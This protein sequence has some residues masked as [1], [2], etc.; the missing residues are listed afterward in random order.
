M[1]RHNHLFERIASFDNLLAAERAALRGKR[2]RRD[3]AAFHYDLE[4][5][6]GTNSRLEEM[7]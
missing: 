7:A 5:N 3:P 1:K 4:P 6:H 2:R